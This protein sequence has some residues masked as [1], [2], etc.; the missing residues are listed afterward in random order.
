MFRSFAFIALLVLPTVT[1]FGADSEFHRIEAIGP[2]LHAMYYEDSDNKSLIV[3]LADGLCLIEAP[4]DR[5]GSTD[6]IEA[7]R[8]G[9]EKVIRTLQHDF[10]ELPLRYL[11][12]SHWHTHSLSSLEPYLE[13]D[14]ELVTTR[15][16]FDRV[17]KWADPDLIERNAD[18]ITFVEDDVLVVG[19]PEDGVIV[20]RLRKEDYQSLP[21]EDYLFFQ[22][23]RSSAL[24]AGCMYSRW[25]GPP[26]AGRE[27]VTG[28]ELD[29]HRFLES[30]DLGVTGLIRITAED[31]SEG[32]ILP[33]SRL[34]RVVETGVTG[35][36]LAER[37][38]ALDTAELNRQRDRLA[39]EAIVD[40]MP[41]RIIN[42][43]AYEALGAGDLDRA[44][45][46][47]HVQALA[48]PAKANAWDT[49]GE[50]HWFRGNQDIARWYEQQSRAIDP[51]FNG[52]G[53]EVWQRN[54]DEHSADSDAS[55][56]R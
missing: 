41:A 46:F 27:L 35:R 50:V 14:V 16:N 15:A 36:E 26:V 10:P 28:R 20:H 38:Q 6:E 43:L 47:A 51:D 45:A 56:E 48:S 8:A 42:S 53:S 52:G 21:T 30:E 32:Q 23:P 55:N 34:D 7:R 33:V 4:A 13:A 11:V 25:T 24:F 31:E 37:Y 12:H 2:G 1:S 49:L 44:L 19:N 22:L 17:L 29:L 39:R 18:Q 9:G 54:L 5:P 40:N 3:E